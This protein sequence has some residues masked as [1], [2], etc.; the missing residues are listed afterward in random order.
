MVAHWCTPTD[1]KVPRMRGAKVVQL[2]L[3]MGDALQG[4][5]NAFVPSSPGLFFHADSASVAFGV[6]HWVPAGGRGRAGEG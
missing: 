4:Q 5:A 2:G 3:E 6:P 1:I